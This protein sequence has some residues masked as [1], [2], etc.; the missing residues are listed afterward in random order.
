MV[1]CILSVFIRHAFHRAFRPFFLDLRRAFEVGG[2][3]SFPVWG[4]LELSFGFQIISKNNNINKY[5]PTSG[6]MQMLHF[7]WL[8]N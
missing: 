6:L 1:T 7:D 4:Q 3:D 2:L 8:R 5:Q